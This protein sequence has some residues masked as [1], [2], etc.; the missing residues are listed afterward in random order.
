M[1]DRANESHQSS[2]SDSD[3]SDSESDFVKT[4]ILMPKSVTLSVGQLCQKLKKINYRFKYEFVNETETVNS[5]EDE[6]CI[7]NAEILSPA[8]V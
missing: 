5:D 4:D 2:A 7:T 1:S 3:H 6:Q 8:K